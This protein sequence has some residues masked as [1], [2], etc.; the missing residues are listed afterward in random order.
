MSPDVNP[1]GI[2]VWRLWFQHS[3]MF[4]WLLLCPGSSLESNPRA[5]SV[6]SSCIFEAC[7]QRIFGLFCYIIDQHSISEQEESCFVLLKNELG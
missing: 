4:S 3:W 5:H 2:S 1:G 6:V 7:V